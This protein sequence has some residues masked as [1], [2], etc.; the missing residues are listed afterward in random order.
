MRIYQPARGVGAA[1][2]ENSFIV[3]DDIGAEVAFGGLTGRMLERMYPER[4]LALEMT[5]DAHPQAADLLFGALLARAENLKAQSGVPA[6][7]YTRCAVEDEN[8]KDYLTRMGFDDF[9]GT[10]LFV[11]NAEQAQQ[12][13]KVYPPAGTRSI[14]VDLGSRVRREQFLLR[15]KASG[16]PEHA[17]EW[18]EERMRGQVFMARAVYAG[19]DLAGELLMTGTPGE[20]LLDMVY[21]AP[22]WRGRGTASAL[23]GEAAALLAGQGTPWL[24]ARA[25]RRNAR[26]TRLFQ[27]CGFDWIRTE[28]LLPG[29]DL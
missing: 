5:F 10:E 27:R 6:R 25:E 29:K 12:R 13:R 4:P 1:L 16:A 7:L 8:K 24:V 17:C 14:D 11:L 28:E 2:Q 26:A 20:A 9:D 21:T 15:L 3:I 18:L 19:S 22:K 23:I